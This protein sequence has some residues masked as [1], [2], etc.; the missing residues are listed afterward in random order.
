MPPGPPNRAA[1]AAAVATPRPNR[2]RPRADRVQS[3][4][5]DLGADLQ[6][7]LS[8]DAGR[9]PAEVCPTGLPALDQLIEGGLPR[10]HLSELTGPTSSGRTTLAL[11]LLA[12]ITEAGHCAGWIDGSNA[13]DPISASAAGVTLNRVLWA[14]PP[15]SQEALRCA[16][17][18]LETEGFPLVVLDLAARAE[19][20]PTH[21]WLRLA[22]LAA[23]TNSALVLLGTQR[24]AGT[25]AYLA[26]ELSPAKAHWSQGLVLLEAI[27]LEVILQRH[28]AVPPGRRVR[29]DLP[30]SRAA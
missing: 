17:R 13:F 9:N 8:P 21:A 29:V 30:G 10:G 6:Q 2:T 28:R 23:S 24:R 22:R 5:R 18:L 7:G 3:L 25:A 27:E 4:L 26:L 14:R 12:K 15:S 20:T 16:E 1:T 11:S 19:A